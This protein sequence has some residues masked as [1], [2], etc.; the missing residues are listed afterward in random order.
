M[1][2]QKQHTKEQPQQTAE[3]I[4]A[5]V[6]KRMVNSE[7][8]APYLL[9]NQATAPPRY[10]LCYREQLDD[11]REKSIIIYPT[12]FQKMYRKAKKNGAGYVIERIREEIQTLDEVT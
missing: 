2:Q 11:H 7:S 8:E 9:L 5:E 4:W 12:L 1:T 3:S 6:S 10:E